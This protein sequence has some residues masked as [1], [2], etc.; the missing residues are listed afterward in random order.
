MRPFAAILSVVIFLSQPAH[1][2]EKGRPLV[3]GLLHADG[4]VLP[5]FI[6]AGTSWKS[7]RSD[8][9]EPT[10]GS[11]RLWYLANDAGP[12]R[13]HV[14][15]TIRYPGPAKRSDAL[16]YRT[17]YRGAT[18]IAPRL[19]PVVGVV[20]SEP[21]PV[22]ALVPVDESSA[23][24]ARVAAR[25]RAD[26]D[27]HDTARKRPR[28]VGNTLTAAQRTKLP[29]RLTVRQ[30]TRPIAG[31][32]V[33]AFTAEREYPGCEIATT[34]GVAVL[35]RDTVRLVR[36][37]YEADFFVSDCKGI[38]AERRDRFAALELNGSL[39]LIGEDMDRATGHLVQRVLALPARDEMKGASAA[40]MHTRMADERG[41]PSHSYYQ[42]ASDSL[43]NNP[44]PF[45]TADTAGWGARIAREL[46]G[47]RLAT[48]RDVACFW[49][50]EF[51]FS[52][53]GHYPWWGSGRAWWLMPGHF[54]GDRRPDVMAFV[55]PTADPR[56]LTLAAFH[57]TGKAYR[58][59]PVEKRGLYD[60]YIPHVANQ[61][62]DPGD[63]S[64]KADGVWNGKLLWAFV[65]G[66]WRAVHMSN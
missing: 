64:L 3:V 65:R 48:E 50:G 2:Q 58:V 20:L 19:G 5:S 14:V 7:I 55:V 12:Q 6:Y 40:V 52:G 54:D 45:H 17:D 39:F 23:I 41:G 9:L 35:D 24:G 31:R 34:H 44:R 56:T 59:G 15:D 46:P 42:C 61:E 32:H 43:V 22:V 63:G 37:E 25:I 66:E 29:I 4:V 62:D 49:N 18:P 16:G 13:L 8:L 1:A 60:P 33:Y 51:G 27:E 38:G 47:Y 57:G 53:V 10:V 28:F 21:R 36:E 30:T 26:F 11:V